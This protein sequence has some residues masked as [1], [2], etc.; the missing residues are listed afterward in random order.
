MLRQ[1][2]A[3]AFAA[4]TTLGSFNPATAQA[5][6]EAAGKKQI[7]NS[8]GVKLVLIPAGQFMMGSEETPANVVAFFKTTYGW[9]NLN[10]NDYRSEHPVHRVRITRPFYLGAC[11]VTVGQFRK[12]AAETKYFTDA[13]N[14]L[15]A[16]QAKGESGQAGKEPESTWRNPGFQQTDDDPVVCVSW[17]DAMTFC[18]WLTRKEHDA[19]RLPTEAE[20]EYACRAGTTTRYWNGDD[21]EALAKV[22]NLADAAGKRRYPSWRAIR[23]SDGY[24]YTSPVASF[25]A[26]PFGLYD[27]HGNVWQ[28]CADWYGADYYAASP[29]DDPA[30]PSS[31]SNRVLRGGSWLTTADSVRSAERFS[32]RPFGRGNIVGFRVAKNP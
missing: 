17:N 29:K 8:I 20:W 16:A 25:P 30:G 4:L 15:K 6:K 1:T 12:F 23:A 13:E 21:P 28:W 9:D 26:N 11:D 2:C 5:P 31:G 7:T 10:A 3:A 27:M 24:V 14:D 19:Y 22:A 18:D 32:A